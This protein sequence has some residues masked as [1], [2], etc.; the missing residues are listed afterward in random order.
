MSSA[1]L[2][3]EKV[4]R[5]PQRLDAAPDVGPAMQDGDQEAD[6]GAW[7]MSGRAQHGS[8]AETEKATME[9]LRIDARKGPQRLK[10]KQAA[11][12]AETDLP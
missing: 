3:A 2:V 11:C 7:R 1:P 8:D 12:R 4:A 10:W 5:P 9:R 6:G